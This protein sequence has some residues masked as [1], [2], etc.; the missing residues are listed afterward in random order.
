MGPQIT[1]SA[2]AIELITNRIPGTSSA[3]ESGVLRKGD[4]RSIANCHLK[5]M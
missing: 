2:V 5:V 3:L 1:P 4:R